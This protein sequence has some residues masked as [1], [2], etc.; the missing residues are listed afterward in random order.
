MNVGRRRILV[1]DTDFRWIRDVSALLADEDLHIEAARS[2]GQAAGMIRNAKYDCVI[3]DV[4][5]QVVREGKVN[6]RIEQL[7]EFVPNEH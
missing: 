4:N 5:F 1:V 6:P 2:I 7:R 3:V